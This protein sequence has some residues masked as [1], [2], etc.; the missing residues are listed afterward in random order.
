MKHKT[1]HTRLLAIAVLYNPHAG[2]FENLGCYLPWVEGLFIWD[3]TPRGEN[4]SGWREMILSR[5]REIYPEELI[6]R[7]VIAGN[8]SNVGL[9]VAYNK[10]IGYAIDNGYTHVMTMD[11]DSQWIGFDRFRKFA[12]MFSREDSLAIIGPSVNYATDGEEIKDMPNIINSGA[13]VP[14]ETVRMIGG[15]CE[16]FLVD[17]VDAEYC[18]RAH[19]NHIRV[20]C[21]SG[22]GFL[23]QK[24]GDYRYFR[25]NGRKWYCTNYSPFRL[26]GILRNHTLLAR[27][28]PE[29]HDNLDRLRNVYLKQYII[30][31]TL[32]ESQKFIKL[33]TIARGFFSG[34]LTAKSLDPKYSKA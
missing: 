27:I 2:A 7:I 18:F 32:R 20:L 24:F 9:S 3:N 26:Y 1:T 4:S 19:R 15:Y 12:D 14:L 34:L 6:D 11:Q 16:R 31:I 23:K 5:L 30:A 29:Q 25:F 28:Y 13:V 33:C 17:A 8:G 22:H 10:G 21:V